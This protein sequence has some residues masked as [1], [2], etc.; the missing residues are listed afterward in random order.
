MEHH[1]EHPLQVKQ[2]ETKYFHRL[3]PGHHP[4]LIIFV[5]LCIQMEEVIS[6]R[7]E[8]MAHMYGMEEAKGAADKA[9]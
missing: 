9:K 3:H 2:G 4:K 8:R 6:L 7:T 1:K 5:F